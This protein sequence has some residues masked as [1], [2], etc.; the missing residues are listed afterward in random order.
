MDTSPAE[1]EPTAE[2]IES[3]DEEKL[4]E[5]IQKN[6]PSL[7]EAGNSDQFLKSGIDGD[8]FLMG[9]GDEDFFM[10]AGL[11]F[12]P[13][14]ELAELAQNVIRK[15]SKCYS[16]YHPRHAEGQ[17]TTSQGTTNRPG[18]RPDLLTINQSI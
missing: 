10:S 7:R 13:S 8:V 3:L 1:N 18:L 11:A 17:L 15:K 16:L 12:R 5:W 6:L 14:I 9:A 2:E 4:F